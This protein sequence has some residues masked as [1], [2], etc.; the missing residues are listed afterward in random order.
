[1]NCTL[2]TDLASLFSRWREVLSFRPSLALVFIVGGSTSAALATPDGTSHWLNNDLGR[3]EI[4]LPASRPSVHP[5]IVSNWADTDPTIGPM[6][7]C[8]RLFR[9]RVKNS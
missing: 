5:V 7:F 3:E 6:I 1:M 2:R 4:V 8:R 9:R